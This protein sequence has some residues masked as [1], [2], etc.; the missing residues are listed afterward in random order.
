MTQTPAWHRQRRLDDLRTDGPYAHCAEPIRLART[1]ADR[2]EGHNAPTK[3]L[4]LHGGVG[5]GKTSIAAAISVQTGCLYWDARALLARLKEEMR[6]DVR[7]SA[8]ERAVRAPVLVLD[9]VGKARSTEWVAEVFRDLV[10]RR[11]DRGGLLILTSNLGPPG[12]AG[13]LGGPVWSR[14]S[15]STVDVPVEGLDLRRIAA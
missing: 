1:W 5:S 2:L 8:L 9:D 7:D 6:V 13:W 12:L 10:E 11:F 4:Y 3:G 14:L 15:A